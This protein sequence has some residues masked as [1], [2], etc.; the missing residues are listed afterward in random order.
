MDIAAVEYNNY[1]ERRKVI[2]GEAPNWGQFIETYFEALPSLLLT[3]YAQFTE[4]TIEVTLIISSIVSLFSLAKSFT[5]VISI[6]NLGVNYQINE[7]D[8]DKNFIVV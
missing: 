3:L 2:F 1:L 7:I 5:N 8:S 6:G 4:G